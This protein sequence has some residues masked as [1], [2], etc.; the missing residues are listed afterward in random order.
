RR[1]TGP[2]QASRRWRPT[3]GTCRAPRRTRTAAV[4]GPATPRPRPALLTW[5][6]ADPEFSR[7]CCRPGLC[8]VDLGVVAVWWGRLA[9]LVRAVRGGGE[10]ATVLDRVGSV[11]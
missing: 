7:M 5:I 11:S 8:S 2:R 4:V 9:E 1:P 3:G 10:S 6:H